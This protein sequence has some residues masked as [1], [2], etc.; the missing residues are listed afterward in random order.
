M[1]EFIY[2][3]ARGDQLNLTDNEFF[4]L[5]H[6]DGQT[7]AAAE[8]SS[9]TNGLIDG[10]IINNARLQP[11]TIITDFTIK[12]T[13]TVETAKRRILEIIKPKQTGSLIWT[14]EGRTLEIMATVEGIDMPRWEEKTVMQITFHCS[15]GTWQDVEDAVQ[16]ISDIINLHYFTD[17]AKD[18]LYLPESG[19][20]FGYYDIART[21]TF[22][23]TGDVAVGFICEVV[24][25]QEV[26]NPSLYNEA[27][28]FMKINTT[29]AENDVLRIDT[30]R[31]EKSITKNGVNIINSLAGGSTWLQIET[32][33]NTFTIASDDEGL[34]RMYF[35][36]K[37]K[38][39]YV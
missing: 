27:G 14:Q 12:N 3:N 20:P 38:Q 2:K 22:N 17:D 33:Y 1:A 10:D 36:I 15:T 39:R 32:G 21:R 29:L 26:N 19:L 9:V 8:L 23:N 31:G 35:L 4:W 7:M 11:R 28:Q 5:T 6:I 30:I 37:Y 18:M 16:K 24:A 25:M 34:N 13:V